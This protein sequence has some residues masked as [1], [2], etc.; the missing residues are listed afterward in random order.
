ML[1]VRKMV[2]VLIDRVNMKF[3]VKLGKSATN[4]YSLLQ[5]Y[6]DECT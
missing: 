2:G 6:D 3:L 4:K 5:V 1:L